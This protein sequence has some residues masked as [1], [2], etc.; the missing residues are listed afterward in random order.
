M[1]TDFDDAAFMATAPSTTSPGGQTIYLPPPGSS[2]SEDG[3]CT[4][5]NSD[6]YDGY[7]T[8][9]STTFG[10]LTDSSGTTTAM[11]TTT[12]ETTPSGFTTVTTVQGKSTTAIGQTS[13]TFTDYEPRIYT[14]NPT[15]NNAY[16]LAGTID[17]VTAVGLWYGTLPLVGATGPYSAPILGAIINGAYGSTRYVLTDPSPTPQGVIEHW[18]SSASQSF[19]TALSRIPLPFGL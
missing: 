4:V 9:I 18:E 5:I 3:V 10:T 6:T 2:L 13:G 7:T 8:Q 1:F 16:V 15:T 19:W 17:T 14:I 11:S 12:T